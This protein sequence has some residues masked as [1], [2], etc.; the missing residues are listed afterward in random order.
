M[1]KKQFGYR[2]IPAGTTP[3]DLY[4][5]AKRNIDALAKREVRLVDALTKD[6][7]A[8]SPFGLREMQKPDTGTPK[9]STKMGRGELKAAIV[10]S[11]QLLDMKTTTVTGA[12]KDMDNKIRAEVGIPLDKKRLNK[13]ERAKMQEARTY[14]E[15]NPE[16]MNDMFKAFDLFKSESM[17]RN[18]DSKQLRN[19]FQ[20][21][22][23]Q[24][25]DTYSD[26]NDLYSA[27]REFSDERYLDTQRDLQRSRPTRRGG[28]K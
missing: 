7:T 5:M 24:K 14:H 22:W 28:F 1:A 12:R 25:K 23:E 21:M 11:Q 16:A 6:P 2:D 26:L 10:R 8:I 13:S 15:D 17:W 20:V 3:R 19:E 9:V 27:V 4:K 18:L